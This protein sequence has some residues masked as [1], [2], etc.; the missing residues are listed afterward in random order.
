[1]DDT[2]LD[3][4]WS[5]EISRRIW[6]ST[7]TEEIHRSQA[8][9]KIKEFHASKKKHRERE[10]RNTT[11]RFQP[12]VKQWVLYYNHHCL[13]KGLNHQ[14][15]INH[16]FNGGFSAQGPVQPKVEPVTKR[17]PERSLLHFGCFGFQWTFAGALDPSVEPWGDIS[18]LK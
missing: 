11:L 1:M 18:W 17:L 2:N 5:S 13:P 6:A 10:T 7:S 9:S 15:W 14:H 4:Q 3:P 12:P 8:A 16:Y